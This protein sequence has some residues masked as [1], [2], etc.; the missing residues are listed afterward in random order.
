[1]CT[2]EPSTQ[3]SKIDPALRFED[4]VVL[5]QLVGDDTEVPR[6][7][8]DP[9]DDKYRACAI[10]GRASFIVPGDPDLLTVRQHEAARIVTPVHF[11]MSS[12]TI[13]RAESGRQ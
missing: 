10:A 9:D 5:S 4:W 6:L 13:E 7:R 11:W 3:P 8:P 2:G 12:S 1:M